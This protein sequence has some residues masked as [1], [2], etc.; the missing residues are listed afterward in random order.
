MGAGDD[1]R[2]EEQVQEIFCVVE[3]E[4]GPIEVCVFNIG[5]NVRFSHQRYHIQGL[6]QGLG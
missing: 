2:I 5:G 4:V 3:K 1:A 6:L